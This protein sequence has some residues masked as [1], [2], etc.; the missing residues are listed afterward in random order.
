[1][2]H[3]P[4]AYFS[5]SFANN[6]AGWT[7]DQSW[8][9]GALIPNPVSPSS[10]NPDPTLDHTPT[11][12]NGVAGVFI[13]GTT[14]STIHTPYYLTSPVIDLSSVNT[15]V[16]L[17]FWRWLNSDYPNYMDSTIEVYNGSSWVKIFSMSSGVGIYDTAWKKMQYDVSAHKNANFRVRFGWSI[18][19]SGAYNVSGWN[20]DDLR[21]VPSASCP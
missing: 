15:E 20:I 7:L 14:G 12:D 1:V 2:T 18:N 6:A 16:I 5:E 11:A 13:G 17:E 10:G 9:I 3:T 8:E 21:L 19:Q 4:F